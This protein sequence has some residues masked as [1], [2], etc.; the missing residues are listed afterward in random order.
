[1]CTVES[2]LKGV[3]P[4]NKGTWLIRILD[5]FPIL[6]ISFSPWNKDTPLIRTVFAEFAVFAVFVVFAVFAVFVVLAE[7]AV[8][9]LFAVLAEFAVF[10]LFAVLAEFA[11]FVMFAVLAEFAVFVMFAVCLHCLQS[12]NLQLC[13]VC[14]IQ[15]QWGHSLASREWVWWLHN[16]LMLRGGILPRAGNKGFRCYEAKSEKAGSPQESNPGH[17]WLEPPVLCH[18]ATATGQPPT[19]TILYMYCTGGTECLSCP[20]ELSRIATCFS[21]GTSLAVELDMFKIHLDRIRFRME[22][23]NV[24]KF[25]SHSVRVRQM[26]YLDHKRRQIFCNLNATWQQ[27][28]TYLYKNV[29]V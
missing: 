20:I 10:A 18:W 1:M 13:L 29:T 7:F 4:W 17:L 14:P 25:S 3:H 11:V 2:L 19:P 5:Q 6:Y 8:F 24:A 28:K 15:L 23:F 27:L 12:L 16:C 26:W 9:A 22:C 21:A